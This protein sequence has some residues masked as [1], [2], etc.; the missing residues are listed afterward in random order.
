MARIAGRAR[1]QRQVGQRSDMSHVRFDARPSVHHHQVDAIVSKQPPGC[2][3][4]GGL[5]FVD[6]RSDE[7]TG[8]RWLMAMLTPL[9]CVPLG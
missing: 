9:V 1:D 6:R 7:A 5:R 3:E 4:I 8:Q 2:H